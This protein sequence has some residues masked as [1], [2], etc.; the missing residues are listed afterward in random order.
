LDLEKRKLQEAEWYR[1]FELSPEQF[2]Q[3]VQNKIKRASLYYNAKVPQE[4]TEKVRD[5]CKV[6]I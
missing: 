3:L 4:R 6:W 2:K 1:E 5:D